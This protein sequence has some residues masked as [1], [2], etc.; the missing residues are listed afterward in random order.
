MA[1]LL[2]STYM[3][4]HKPDPVGSIPILTSSCSYMHIVY[5]DTG[6]LYVQ[7]KNNFK[8]YVA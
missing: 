7:N 3:A 1:R 2:P 6:M 5:T 4:A 8:N